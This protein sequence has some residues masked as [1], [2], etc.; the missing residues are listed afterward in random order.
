MP[1]SI[2]LKCEA[3]AAAHIIGAAEIVFHFASF[4]FAE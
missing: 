1:P 2:M 3:A 4:H